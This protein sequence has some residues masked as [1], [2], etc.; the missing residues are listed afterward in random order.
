MHRA[1]CAT[2]NATLGNSFVVSL[3]LPESHLGRPP[4][5]ELSP[6]EI[7]CGGL[8]KVQHRVP[9]KRLSRRHSDPLQG[10]V[11]YTF[12]TWLPGC[13]MWHIQPDAVV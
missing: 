6:Q 9:D 4:W 7:C 1:A 5:S 13:L 12:S 8:V 11:D 10:Q 3:A 2:G